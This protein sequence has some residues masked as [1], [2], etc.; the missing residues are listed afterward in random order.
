MIGAI[1]AWTGVIATVVD[2]I[3]MWRKAWTKRLVFAAMMFG[4]LYAVAVSIAAFVDLVSPFGATLAFAPMA[5]AYLAAVI[6]TARD[7]D[8]TKL[9]LEETL[10]GFA[11]SQGLELRELN[12]EGVPDDGKPARIR[13]LPGGKR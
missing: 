12:V 2:A 8:V 4:T 1:L 13:V 11:K 6:V 3:I 5:S 7:R 10:R 9:I